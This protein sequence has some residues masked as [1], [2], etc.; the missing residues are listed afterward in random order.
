MATEESPGEEVV[1]AGELEKRLRDPNYNN[2]VPDPMGQKLVSEAEGK[3]VS[4]KSFL[5]KIFGGV[6][7]VEEAG[8]AFHRA[9]WL[10]GY[11]AVCMACCATF[12]CN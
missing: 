7:R 11:N 8:E 1:S 6:Q 5:G 10:L 2:S 12:L 4:S 9:G 3:L